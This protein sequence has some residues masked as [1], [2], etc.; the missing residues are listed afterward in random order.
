MSSST[1]RSRRW[2]P[3]LSIRLLAVDLDFTLLDAQRELQPDGVLA[4]REA[5]A[6]GITVV[7]ASG[8][9]ASSMRHYSEEIGLHSP[10]ISS[11]GCIVEVD[12]ERLVDERL[13]LAHS[14]RALRRCRE[15]GIHAHVYADDTIFFAEQSV[16]SDLYLSRIRKGAF[17]FVGWEALFDIAPLK[18]LAVADPTEIAS[19]KEQI[20]PEMPSAEVW[21]TMSEPEYLE[22]LSARANKGTGLKVVAERLGIAREETAA[23]GDYHN[24]IPMLEFAGLSAAVENAVPELKRVADHIVPRFDQGGVPAF[25]SLIVH[26]SGQ[27]NPPSVRL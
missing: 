6:R 22:F 8:R 11:N 14:H 2:S 15:M 7:L 25:I 24:D 12:G 1:L 17:K 21:V 16:W 23:I 19:L 3:K 10:L 26:N 20:E 5:A 13:D 18:V 4:L 27:S 9:V